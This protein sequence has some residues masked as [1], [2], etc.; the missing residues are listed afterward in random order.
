LLDDWSGDGRSEIV[1]GGYNASDEESSRVWVL[2][3]EDSY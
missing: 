2:S 3:S 1:I